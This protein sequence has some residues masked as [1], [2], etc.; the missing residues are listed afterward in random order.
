MLDYL[1]PPF[2]KRN[3]MYIPSFEVTA[4]HSN[5]VV[6]RMPIHTEDSGT[7]RLLDV[8]THPPEEG[9]PS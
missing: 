2:I 1:P 9:N 5:E 7:Q 8:L 6:I 4:T 3:T